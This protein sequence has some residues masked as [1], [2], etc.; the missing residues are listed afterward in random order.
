VRPLRDDFAALVVSGEQCELAP[1]ALAIARIAYPALEPGPHL[2]RLDALAAGAHPR[3]RPDMPPEE[4]AAA[5]AAYLFGECGFRG[6]REDYYD[7]RNSFLNDVLERRTGIPISLAVVLI[8]TAARLGLA[9]E[10]VGFPGHFLVRAPGARA[11]VVLDPFSGGRVVGED[12]LLDRW[13]ATQGSAARLPRGALETA[14][15]LAILTRMLR[16]LLAV[17]LERRD[18]VHALEAVELLLVL[19]PDAPQSLRVRGL[20]LADLDYAAGALAD[21]R[22]Y[23]ELAPGAPDAAVVRERIADL[24]RTAT[25]VH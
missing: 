7:P 21:L 14:G 20:L 22:R 16:N 3:L 10:G 18:Q 23:L 13:R 19:G 6:N 24:E 2:A 11:P 8:E 15:R 9:L 17:Y 5:L 4:A 25:T 12:E 1:A